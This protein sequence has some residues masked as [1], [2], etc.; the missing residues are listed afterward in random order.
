MKLLEF[1]M[2]G[3]L[4]SLNKSFLCVMGGSEEIIGLL[5]VVFVIA[6]TLLRICINHG[7]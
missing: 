7:R 5:K 3:F 6:A 1:R 4:L 2:F